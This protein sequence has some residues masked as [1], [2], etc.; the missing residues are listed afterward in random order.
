MK[1]VAQE[2]GVICRSIVGDSMA[3][4]GSAEALLPQLLQGIS[5]LQ[6]SQHHMTPFHP[7]VLQAYVSQLHFL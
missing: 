4:S 2:A 1:A 6:P 3:N 7:A 5:K